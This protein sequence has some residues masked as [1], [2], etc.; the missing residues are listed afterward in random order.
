[1]ATIVDYSIVTQRMTAAGFRSLYYNSGAFGFEQG[2]EAEII[3]WIGPEDSSIR[4]HAR[5]WTYPVPEPFAPNLARLLCVAWC[6]SLPGDLWLMPK[7][8]WAYEL[9]FGNR[10]W[11]PEVLTAVS[12]NPADLQKLTNAAA[13]Q[14]TPTDTEEL[15]YF[16]RALLDKLQ[17]SDFAA[18]FPA[19]GTVATLHHHTQIWWQ[20]RI[21]S[22]AL[23]LRTLAASA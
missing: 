19:H 21:P 17:G 23:D 18:V 2:V 5:E 20:T 22:I 13:I 4:D 6:K 15:E 9:D 7:S 8:H 14:F 12:I 11:L 3:G 1:M 10:E 16:T